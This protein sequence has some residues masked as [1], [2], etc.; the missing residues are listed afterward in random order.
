[1]QTVLFGDTGFRVS[2]LGFGGATAGIKN[3]LGAFDPEKAEDRDPII[4]A[5]QRAVELGV[6]YFDTAAGYGDGASETLFGEAMQ[7]AKRDELY[8]ASKFGVWNTKEVRPGLE[9]TLKRMRIDY[10]DLLQIH[11]T[12][13]SKQHLGDILHPGGFLDQLE[14]LQSQ[15]MIRH[16]GFT[17][18]GSDPAMVQLFETGRFDAMQ[19]QYNL[20]FQHLA[21]FS[22]K[23]GLLFEAAK[24]GIAT[25]SMRSTT[26]GLLQRWI[27]RVN[28]S[29][30]FDYT[31][32]LI[33][34]NLS[35]PLIDVVLVGMRT[36]EEVEA[37]VALVDD[38]SGRIDLKE[39]FETKQPD[40]AAIASASRA[41]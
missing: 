16:I 36:V 32:A 39:L 9:E 28:P 26:S 21:D 33:Q 1:M 37:N 15:G 35:N 30:E 22:R 41:R 5:I 2:R 23:S 19:V 34:F 18:E 27:A 20:C 29:N 11:G 3:Y 7:G 12:I 40:H 25:I 24:T 10:L 38:E 4:A 13:Y 8:L 6:T 14:K 31:P 17:G